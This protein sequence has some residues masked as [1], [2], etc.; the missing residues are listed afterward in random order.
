MPAEPWSRQHGHCAQ[1]LPRGG[2]VAPRSA[3]ASVAGRSART[4]TAAQGRCLRWT[5][6][7]A[8]QPGSGLRR[9]GL[10]IL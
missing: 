10:H 9:P 2:A 8:L 7:P 5:G 3:T 6:P 4:T 1:P